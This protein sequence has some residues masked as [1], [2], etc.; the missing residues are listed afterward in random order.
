M[1]RKNRAVLP[2]TQ[3][4]GTD[5]NRN[6][7][8]HWGGPGSSHIPCDETFAGLQPA[9]EPEVKAVIQLILSHKD[10]I[11]AFITLHSYGQMI[12]YPWVRLALMSECLTMLIYR[13]GQTSI[14]QMLR[15]W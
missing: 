8:F 14:P 13:A 2:N 6:Y 12:L 7:P 10:R 1:W 5:L 3:C 15:N 9:S 4:I 11:K